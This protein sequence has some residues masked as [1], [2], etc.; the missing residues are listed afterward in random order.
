MLSWHKTIQHTRKTLCFLFCV[1]VEASRQVSSSTV[2]QPVSFFVTFHLFSIR[3]CVCV[4]TRAHVHA[5]NL[6]LWG[7]CGVRSLPSTHGS[8]L[9]Q[10]RQLSHLTSPSPLLFKTGCFTELELNNQIWLADQREHQG[11]SFLRSPA[12]GYKWTL[13]YLAF[14][15]GSR[16]LNQAG[17]P[18]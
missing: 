16:A 14:Y 6:C 9:A 2:L 18:V 11:S 8:R 13:A 10:V 3:V 15:Q 7:A 12:L 5:C 4:Y 17:S 1:Y